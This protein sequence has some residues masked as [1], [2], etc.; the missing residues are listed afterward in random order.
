MTASAGRIARTGSL[1]AAALLWTAPAF[2]QV[3]H[4]AQFGFGLFLPRGIDARDGNDVLLANLAPTG[5]IPGLDDSL[6]FD[7][8]KTDQRRSCLRPFRAA[9]V[10]GEWNIAF[11]N[12]L[13]VGLGAGFQSR[14]VQS[15]YTELFNSVTNRDIEQDIGLRLIPV[16]ALVRF[17]PIG[18]PGSVQPYVGVG[19]SAINFRYTEIGDFF[20]PFDPPDENIFFA[21]VRTTGNAVGPLWVVGLRMPIDGDIYAMNAEWRYQYAKGKL[22]TDFLTDTIDLGGGQFNLSFLVRF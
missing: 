11:G 3:V 7:F 14:T 9:H 16:T 6:E 21:N 22:P 19:V 10:S 18:R 5:A 17:M 8:C 20:A 1:L 13:E 15:R 4:S 12:R 2:A